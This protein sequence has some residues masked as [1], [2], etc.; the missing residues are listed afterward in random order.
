MKTTVLVALGLL[1]G[2]VPARAE[3]KDP[4]A[5]RRSIEVPKLSLGVGFYFTAADL[6]E[7]KPGSSDPQK[8]LDE[9]RRSLEGGAGDA[10]QYAEIGD[11]YVKLKDEEH[12][13]EAYGR[14][15]D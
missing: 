14:A 7:P 4:A 5:L 2:A 6:E 3:L 1:A 13:R 15:A 10:G 12:A 9:L 8:R 11:L